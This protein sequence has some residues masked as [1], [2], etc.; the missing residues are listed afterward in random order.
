MDKKREGDV[1]S[2]YVDPKWTDPTVEARMENEWPIQPLSSISDPVNSPKHYRFGGLELID[3]ID[4]MLN[5]DMFTPTEG[6]Y[7]ATILQY[8][9]RFPRKNGVQDLNKARYY[10]DRLIKMKGREED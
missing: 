5:E 9:I 6:F 4:A 8:M 2:Q 1:W 7:V 10:L 3:I